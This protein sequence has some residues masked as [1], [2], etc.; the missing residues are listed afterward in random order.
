MSGVLRNVDVLSS[1]S[2]FPPK[3]FDALIVCWKLFL[4]LDAYT[5]RHPKIH[6]NGQHLLDV[7]GD[8]ISRYI[9]FDIERC[10]ISRR[11]FFQRCKAVLEEP[12][13]LVMN[14][15]VLDLDEFT[16]AI[17]ACLLFI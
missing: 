13:F 14:V 8:P 7:S 16:H 2:T 11:H 15:W 6:A 9:N 3:T 17:V 5:T 1:A 10:P 12:E 4:S